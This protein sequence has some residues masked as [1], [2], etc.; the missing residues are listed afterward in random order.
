MA[1]DKDK[2]IG[3]LEDELKRSKERIAEL[4]DEVDELRETQDHMREHVEEGDRVIES[5]RETLNMELNS[6]NCWTWKPFWNEHNQIIDE[7]NA[8]VARFN[9]LVRDWNTHIAD[10][11]ERRNVGRPLAASV[12][13][14]RRVLQLRKGGFDLET[15]A[16]ETVDFRLNG[17][18]AAKLAHK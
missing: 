16:N 17:F 2:R 8:L 3:E 18:E 1:D 7:H 9:A 6:D 4:K 13:Q 11:K 12:A 15:F 5:W 10:A 14:V